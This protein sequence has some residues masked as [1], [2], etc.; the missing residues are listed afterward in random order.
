MVKTVISNFNDLLDENKNAKDGEP[1]K[2]LLF[3]LMAKNDEILIRFW[4]CNGKMAS[5]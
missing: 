2:L 4:K 3:G 1:K 5:C